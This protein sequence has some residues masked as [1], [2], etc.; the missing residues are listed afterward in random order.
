MLD[1]AR[2]RAGSD[3]ASWSGPAGKAARARRAEP[4]FAGAT[5]EI[6]VTRI[7]AKAQITSREKR[8]AF[9]GV[10]LKAPAPGL[11]RGYAIVLAAVHG[12]ED[13]VLAHDLREDEIVARWRGVAASLGL[14]MMLCHANGEMEFL[15]RQL[16]GVTLGREQARRRRRRK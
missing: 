7:V 5:G 16:G 3:A 2:P 8:S 15:H 14:P 9:Q 13:V 11:R 12:N 10:M 4:A 1:T 6:V